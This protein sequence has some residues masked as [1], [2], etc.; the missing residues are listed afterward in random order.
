MSDNKKITE[1]QAPEE[2]STGRRKALKKILVGTGVISGSAM[3][4]SAWTKPIVD[5]IIVPAHAAVS[6]TTYEPTTSPSPSTTF[7]VTTPVPTSTIQVT[8]PP[9]PSST[10]GPTTGP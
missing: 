1:N 5:S 7:Q 8:T 2:H 9:P 6:G 10:P 3:L 4:P